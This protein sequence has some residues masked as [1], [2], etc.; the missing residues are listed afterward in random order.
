MIKRVFV[1]LFCLCGALMLAQT[2]SR[3]HVTY[4]NSYCGGAR[5]TPEI[6]QEAITPRDFHDVH[7]VFEGRT[8]V[9]VK[10]DSAGNFT[11]SLKPGKYKV[12]LTKLKNEAHY[13]NYDPACSKM[14]KAV[15]GELI[16]TKGVYDY[17]LNLH[18]PCNPCQL[19]K[20]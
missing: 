20:P 4:T 16:V 1:Y 8:R 13:T 5:P 17:L 9:K 14:L 7:M 11:A 12:R 6:E 19:P 2:K 10:T 3:V 15:Y 18:F